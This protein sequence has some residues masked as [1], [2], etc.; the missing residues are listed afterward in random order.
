[1][2]LTVSLSFEVLESFPARYGRVAEP[3]PM[4]EG[5]FQHF[6]LLVRSLGIYVGCLSWSRKGWNGIGFRTGCD[7][8]NVK[9][10]CVKEC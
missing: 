10:L 8:V 2:V 9:D 3:P 5:F 4:K 7:A 1:M 6:K